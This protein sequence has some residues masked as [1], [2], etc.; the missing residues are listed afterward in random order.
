MHGVIDMPGN[1]LFIFSF[2]CT[3]LH[4]L[5]TLRLDHGFYIYILFLVFAIYERDAW[6]PIIRFIKPL[7]SPD[8]EAIFVSQL[9]VPS[10]KSSHHCSF[11]DLVHTAIPR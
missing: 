1:I 10:F 8:R 5:C 9:Q 11:V 6:W 4:S 7:S 2:R 3:Q